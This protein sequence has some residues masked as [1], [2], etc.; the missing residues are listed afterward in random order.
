MA[1][2][3]GSGIWDS[4]SNTTI[5]NCYVHDFNMLGSYDAPVMIR[6]QKNAK[7]IN[8]TVTRGGR[9]ALQIISKGSVI[10]SYSIHY[11]KLYEG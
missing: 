4:G 6:G 2:G 7:L 3:D 11:T 9:D 5:N 8:S 1:Y 10:T